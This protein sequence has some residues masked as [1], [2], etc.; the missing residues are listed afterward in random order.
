MNLDEIKRELI[1]RSVQVAILNIEGVLIDTD[2]S[3]LDLRSSVGK[4]LFEELDA[5]Y[6]L[7]ETAKELQPGDPPLLLPIIN[8][9]VGES[10][11]LLNLEIHRRENDLMLVFLNQE[12]MLSRLRDMQQERNDSMILLDKIRAQEQELRATNERLATANAELDRFAYVVSHDLKSP[13]RGIRNLSEWISEG[14]AEG[15]L[16]ELE[17]N[18]RL[19]RERSHHMERLIDAILQYSRAGRRNMPAKEVHIAK[20]VQEIFEQA[21]PGSDVWLSLPDHLPVFTTQATWLYQVFSNLISNA[22]KYGKPSN[23][24]PHQITIAYQDLSDHHQFTVADQGPGIPAEHQERI[25]EIFETLGGKGEYEQTGIGLSI[26]RKLVQEADGEIS[27]ASE[28]GQGSTF[29]FT[30]GKEIR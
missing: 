23:G 15:D 3:L 27:V 17:T 19:I 24:N 22:I 20:M 7:E 14:L 5:L 21:A 30:W 10:E 1:D 4:N 9:K 2:H 16:E 29:T 28:T 6:G 13:L 11:S 8:F 25:F 18:V 12:R 26:V